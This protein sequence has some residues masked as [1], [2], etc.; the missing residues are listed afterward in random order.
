MSNVT[1]AQVDAICEFGAN[2]SV[3]LQIAE[4]ATSL[5]NWRRLWA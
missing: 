4:K 1:I 3:Q 5:Y 2:R